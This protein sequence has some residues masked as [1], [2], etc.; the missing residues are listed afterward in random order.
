MEEDRE[1]LLILGRPFLAT[2]RALIDVQEGEIEL[3]VQD[4]KVT[5]NVFDATKFPLEVDS[6]LRVDVI[7]EVVTSSFGPI[8][9]TTPL[10]AYLVNSK[11]AEELEDNN[12]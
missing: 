3:R 2:G 7:K 1:V 12:L 10:K 6:Y 11:M 5:F 8:S 4:E 9:T